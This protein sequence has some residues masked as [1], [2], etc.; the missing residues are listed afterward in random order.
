MKSDQ[1][2]YQE[3]GQLLMDAGP[4]NAQ[5]LLVKAELFSDGDGGRYEFDY[6]DRSGVLN[7]FDPDGRA[8]RNLTDLL[9]ELREYFLVNNLASGLDPWT[10]CKIS[11]VVDKMK[12][13][14]E[15]IYK[16]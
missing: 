3:I 11:L 1:E 10:G 9:V 7:W 12:F 14:I 15:F 8:V 13:G 6:V 5:E 2:I 4:S 16:V